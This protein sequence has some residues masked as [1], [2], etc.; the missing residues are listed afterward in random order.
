MFNNIFEL[1]TSTLALLFVIN[2]GISLVIIFLD[3][4]DPSST[5]A[6]IMVLFLLPFLG[7]VLYIIFSQ[8]LSKKRIFRYTALEKRVMESSL[9]I[10][11][12]QM[13]TGEFHFKDKETE[14]YKDMIYMHQV[15]SNAIYTDDNTVDVFT[16][17]HEKFSMLLEDIKNAKAHIHFMYFILQRDRLGL[18]IIDALTQKAEE[19]L[20]V[21]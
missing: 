20:E 11:I 10:Q 8:N 9:K 6:W 2:F 18:N 4:K 14:P 21:R 3:K 1:T 16:N 15:Q 7:I 19:G 5:L 13:Q 17:G 12:D